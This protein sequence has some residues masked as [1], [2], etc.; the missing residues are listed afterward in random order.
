MQAI[1]DT[2]K[3][4]AALGVPVCIAAGDDGSDDQVGDGAAHVDFPSTS[5]YVLC[6]GGTALTKKNGAGFA[7][8]TWFDGDGLRKDGGGSTGGGVSA[9]IARPTWQKAITIASVNPQ[10]PAGR[11]VPDVAANAAGSTGYFMV[12]QGQGQVSGGTSA[13]APLWAALLARLMANG[14]KVGYFTPL[15][16]QTNGKTAGKPLGA[17]ALSDITAG[18]NAT[19]A[20]GGYKA[21]AGFDAVTGW[22]SPNGAN[23]MKML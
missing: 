10:G 15:L 11:C 13:A 3:E 14:K 9:T 12:A 4:A 2:L 5:P 7:E 18:G 1:N 19:A 8:S 22:G 17:A 21:G 16:Y 23:L 6:V 20:A